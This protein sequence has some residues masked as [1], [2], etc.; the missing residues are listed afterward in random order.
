M[1][2]ANRRDYLTRSLLLDNIIKTNTGIVSIIYDVSSPDASV[3]SIK[4]SSGGIVAISAIRQRPTGQSAKRS[5][6]LDLY[7]LT[8][9]SPS[10]VL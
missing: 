2:K 3:S 8:A 9:S 5:C 1:S 10:T 7:P 4:V 6:S